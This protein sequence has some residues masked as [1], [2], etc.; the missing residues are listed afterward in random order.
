MPLPAGKY[1]LMASV[2]LHNGNASLTGADAFVGCYFTNLTNTT[3]YFGDAQTLVP[4]P[5]GIAT[6]FHNVASMHFQFPVDLS[7][8][9]TVMFACSTT[10]GG[11]PS[12]VDYFAVLTA[13]QLSAINVLP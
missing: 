2:K 6:P 11:I 1:L 13:L 10:D 5:G 4:S 9:T 8:A 7:Q 12:N 3:A